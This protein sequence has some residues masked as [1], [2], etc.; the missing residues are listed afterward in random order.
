MATY[1]RR[2]MSSI[3]E[4]LSIENSRSKLEDYSVI[5]LFA[6]G[7]FY[8]AYDFSAW[9]CV[10]F[11]NNFKP[12][13]RAY[14]NLNAD[15]VY[16]GFPLTSLE[17]WTPLSA[18]VNQLENKSVEFVLPEDTLPSPLN[19]DILIEEYSQWKSSIPLSEPKQE[20]ETKTSVEKHAG[21]GN[22]QKHLGAMSLLMQ[23]LQFPVESKTP[24]ESQQFL[25]DVKK[26][27]LQLFV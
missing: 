21:S 20:T 5:H 24:L 8:R 15:A 13:R 9:L 16:I 10:K 7:S 14:K 17:K 1:T 3:K 11:I 27:I 22:H 2:N 25:L 4:I 19:V 18:K 6:D 26:D 23:V 12:T